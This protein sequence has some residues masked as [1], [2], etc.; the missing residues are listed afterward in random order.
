MRAPVDVLADYPQVLSS[1]PC[2]CAVCD[3]RRLVEV[4]CP[5]APDASGVI[6]P[7]PHCGP[8]NLPLALPPRSAA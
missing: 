4:L 6:A 2:C 5:D 8:L 7:C 1:H 3:G